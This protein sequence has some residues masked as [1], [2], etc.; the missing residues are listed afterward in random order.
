MI[1]RL[2]QQQ[3]QKQEAGFALLLTLVIVSV[4][5]AIGLSLLDI[6]LKQLILSGTARDSEI[7]FHAAYAGVECAE[8]YAREDYTEFMKPTPNDLADCVGAGGDLALYDSGD[9]GEWYRSKY[10]GD[11]GPV[12]DERC[13]E[14]DIYILDGVGSGGPVSYDFTTEYGYKN[15][16]CTEGAICTFIFARGYNRACSDTGTLGTIQREVISQF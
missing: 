2:I 8:Y 5:L 1:D 12:G 15:V 11:W 9:N 7:A 6:T 13:S 16:T 14:A 3:K 4:V 10:R